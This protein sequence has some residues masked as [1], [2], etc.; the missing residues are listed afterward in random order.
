MTIFKFI[1]CTNICLKRF[2]ATYKVLRICFLLL[3]ATTIMALLFYLA[4]AAAI[5][6]DVYDAIYIRKNIPG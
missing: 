5:E 6:N 4:G 1:D 3:I 2:Y